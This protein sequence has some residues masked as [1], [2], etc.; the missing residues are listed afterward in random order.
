M[1]GD[2]PFAEPDDSDHTRIIRPQPGGRAR[3]ATTPAAPVPPQPLAAP[4]STAGPDMVR[5]G[6][7]ALIAAAS[8]LLQLLSRLRNTLSQPDSGD[9]RERA[10]AGIR[11]FEQVSRD[12]G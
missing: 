11:R 10:G 8:P 9:L 2:N 5:V 6:S 7:S 3:N 1:S 12:T 4:A